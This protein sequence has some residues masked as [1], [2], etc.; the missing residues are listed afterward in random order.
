M[1]VKERHIIMLL[2]KTKKVTWRDKT[3]VWGHLINTKYR[4]E[5][6]QENCCNQHNTTFINMC[7]INTKERQF[8]VLLHETKRVAWRNKT[9]V[10]GLLMNTGKSNTK[11]TVVASTALIL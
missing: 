8:T 9:A 10:W 11:K 5:E 4:Q 3:D 6:C 1:N 7:L 2:H